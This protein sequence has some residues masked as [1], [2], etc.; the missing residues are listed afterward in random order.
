[1]S[2]YV[3]GLA[4]RYRG[5][6]YVGVTNDLSRRVGD[7]KSGFV[8][9]LTKNYKVHTL[10]YYEEY[11]S[12]LEARARER[13]LKRWRREWKF[14]LI[15]E[16]NPLRLDLTPDLVNCDHVTG[17]RICGASLRPAPRAGPFTAI[18]APNPQSPEPPRPAAR[19]AA[20]GSRSG[21]PRR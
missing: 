9:G 5:T 11:A 6:L 19:A 20:R 2:Y 18:F 1:M 13:V 8:P 12:I 15:E 3:Y 14:R 4:S 7:H 17:V 16:M 10:V 21:S